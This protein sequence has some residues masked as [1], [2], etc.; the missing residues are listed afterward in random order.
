VG[1]S[2]C[3][4]LQ[5]TSGTPLL[6]RLEDRIRGLCAKAVATDDTAELRKVLE[7]LR[8]A[9]HDHTK[10]LRKLAVSPVPPERR[11]SL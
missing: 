11:C 7:E 10:R 2:E 3:R 4:S 9:I 5:A 8:A 6:R 1:Y